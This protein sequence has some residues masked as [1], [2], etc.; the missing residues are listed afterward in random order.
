[1]MIQ[2]SI[3]TLQAPTS[4][5]GSMFGR[6]SASVLGLGMQLCHLPIATQRQ[7][8]MGL[9]E[10]RQHVVVL[11]GRGCRGIA[12]KAEA[13]VAQ[14]YLSPA[15][16]RR[17]L[18]ETSINGQTH[19]TGGSRQVMWRWDASSLPGDKQYASLGTAAK[20]YQTTPRGH[21]RQ[22]AVSRNSCTPVSWL[23]SHV[24]RSMALAL[25]TSM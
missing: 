19:G 6:S 15:R 14:G 2:I 10:I 3:S 8:L 23:S 18:I 13:A 1:M 4:I 5:V 24:D 25:L 21:C 20:V 9:F 17:R 12:C 7:V 16:H 11:S 22:R